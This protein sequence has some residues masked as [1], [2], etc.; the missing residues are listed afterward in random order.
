LARGMFVV[1]YPAGLS[2]SNDSLGFYVYD[3]KMGRKWGVL[4][5]SIDEHCATRCHNPRE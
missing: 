4:S 3:V 2:I 5:L 1:L